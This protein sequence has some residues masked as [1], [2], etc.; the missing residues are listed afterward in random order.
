MS[1]NHKEYRVLARKYRPQNF[2]Q[3]IG[4]DALVRTLKTA[5]ETGRI[6]HAYMLT[7]VRGV[8]KTTTAR[9]IAR[10][11][12]YVGPDGK[13]GPTTGPTDDCDICKAI[14][15]DR[16]P[17]VMEMDAA[18]RT[19]IDDIR[20]ILDGVR[21][22]P[23]QARY[24]VYIIDEVHML[25]KNA[26]NALLKTLEEPPPHVIFIFAT[27]E[28][29]KVPVTVLSRCQRFN[30][31]RVDAET[32]SKYYTWVSTQE[33]VGIEDEAV[34]MIARAADG[35][36][37]DG[38]SILDQAMAQGA[39]GTITTTQVRD[40]LGL[41]D[42]SKLLDL[43]EEILKGDCPKALEMM[44]D[45]Y[46]AGADPSSVIQ[47]LLDITHL[48]SKF[49]A[50]SAPPQTVEPNMAT[51]ERERAAKIAS[52]V[53]MPVLG[54]VWQILLKGLSEVQ[55]A[56]NP[57]SAAEM[58]V[59]RLAYASTL[60]DP[61]TLVKKLQEGGS[62]S[63]PSPRGNGNGS[64]MGGS[65]ASFVSGASPQVKAVAHHQNEPVAIANNNLGTLQDVVSLL[66][67]NGAMILSSNVYQY[68]ELVKLEAGVLEFSTLP[69]APPKLSS[70]LLKKLNEITGQRWMVSI[71]AKKG[72]P[73]LAMQ[74]AAAK[75][76]EL[77]DIKADPLV[78]KIFD[79]FPGAEIISIKP[80]EEEI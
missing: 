2:D 40:M 23:T 34:A 27:T 63:S 74:G 19:G 29:R 38:L 17:D 5:I 73:T 59:I 76:Q 7:G 32:L 65:T 49:Q 47:D 26:F 57:Q 11:L 28:I 56:S 48:M 21:Y 14:M 25:S 9:I 42:R 69:N 75:A 22:A 54:R 44:A 8:G 80:H 45:L 36:V 78:K 61:A 51:Q 18:S 70:D 50:I 64:S 12:N 15:E 43:Y 1:E 55:Y 13:A 72:Q 68:V 20:E 67:Q 16:H 35:S 66:E 30:L 33:K 53:T 39:G 46:R 77:E 10:A 24:K 31:R 52:S 79:T 62:V 4:Q 6:A 41:A 60:P 71:S 3:L 58:V 37:R